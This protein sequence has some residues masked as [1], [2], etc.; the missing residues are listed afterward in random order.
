LKFRGEDRA[1]L[2][3]RDRLSLLAEALATVEHPYLELVPSF[4]NGRLAVHQLILD[5]GG[6][7]T[8]WKHLDQPYEPGRRVT[9]WLKRKREISIEAI[10]IGSKPGTA[11]HGNRDL[12][13]A[14]EFAI[15]FSDGNV[16]P[17][18]WVS[19]WSDY[20]RRAMTQI[21]SNGKPKLNSQY[22]GRRAL[23]CGQDE[24]TR[25]G[26][27]RHARFLVW[28]GEASFPLSSS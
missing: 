7:G 10:V 12:V 15:R 19:N 5:A 8:V 21:D 28:A 20:E 24:S 13:G 26:R 14:V 9:H 18:A 22:M 16:R 4:C 23:I 27:M 11:D 17:I 2:P 25:S 1:S 3:L 6:E